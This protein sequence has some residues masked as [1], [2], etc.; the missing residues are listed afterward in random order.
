L[1]TTDLLL[2][3]H[4][5][6]GLDPYGTTAAS[7]ISGLVRSTCSNSAGGTWKRLEKIIRKM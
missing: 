5:I 2:N 1:K 7:A 6:K 3:T 4:K